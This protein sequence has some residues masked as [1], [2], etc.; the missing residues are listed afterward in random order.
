MKNGDPLTSEIKQLNHGLLSFKSMNV[1]V[2]LQGNEIASLQTNDSFLI[3]LTSDLGITGPKE[4]SVGDPGN[5]GEFILKS[6]SGGTV[7]HPA[8]VIEIQQAEESVGNQLKG[9]AD[10]GLSYSSGTNRT[11]LTFSAA[12]RCPGSKMR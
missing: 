9:D 6:A 5:Q 8:Q 7:V 4:R 12:A 2:E 10:F 11:T 3:N 1:S